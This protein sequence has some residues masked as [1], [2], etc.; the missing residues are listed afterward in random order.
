MKNLY[1]WP[2]NSATGY[3]DP[4]HYGDATYGIYKRLTELRGNTW[5]TQQNPN[6][7]TGVSDA[8]WVILQGMNKYYQ[9]DNSEGV[10]ITR[11]DIWN[12]PLIMSYVTGH[13]SLY[14]QTGWVLENPDDNFDF[15]GSDPVDTEVVLRMADDEPHGYRDGA[16][17]Y[18]T[19]GGYLSAPIYIDSGRARHAILEVLDST[20]VRLW[21]HAEYNDDGTVDNFYD[22]YRMRDLYGHRDF[23]N[24]TVY[25]SRPIVI[26]A[27]HSLDYA[28]AANVA[29]QRLTEQTNVAFS[30]EWKT[31]ATVPLPKP[32]LPVYPFSVD[33]FEDYINLFATPVSDS[34]MLISESFDFT[35][36]GSG[37]YG[38]THTYTDDYT[39]EQN[40]TTFPQFDADFALFYKAN[41]G[42]SNNDIVNVTRLDSRELYRGD[43]TNEQ[44]LATRGLYNVYWVNRLDDDHFFLTIVPYDVRTPETTARVRAADNRISWK[45]SVTD[46][47]TPGA[48][49]IRVAPLMSNS[50]GFS[51]WR[52]PDWNAVRFQTDFSAPDNYVR[53]FRDFSSAWGDELVDYNLRFGYSGR[54]S[55]PY[56]TLNFY[57][58]HFGNRVYSYTDSDGNTVKTN[59]AR[60]KPGYCY[61]EGNQLRALKT[62]ATPQYEVEYFADESGTPSTPAMAEVMPEFTVTTDSDGYLSGV[63]VVS[64]GSFNT[65]THYTW[66]VENKPNETLNT[67]PVSAAT[68]TEDNWD[69]ADQWTTTDDDASRVWPDHMR[70]RSVRVTMVQPNS[71]NR[72][73]SGIKY[74]RNTGIVRYQVEVEYPAMTEEQFT[75]FIGAVQAARGQYRPFYLRLRYPDPQAPGREVGILFNNAPESNIQT[76]L[77]VVDVDATGKVLTLDGFPANLSRAVSSGQHIGSDGNRNGG[78]NTIIQDQHSNVYG[79]S[80]FRI[81]YPSF[82]YGVGDLVDLNPSVAVVTLAEDNFEYA[83]DY[84][85][86]YKLKV[87][88]D[89]DEFK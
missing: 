10:N 88:F 82:S 49:D 75:P 20:R 6:T 35:M 80:K 69:T 47:V 61:P 29:D 33:L 59:A 12:N 16:N 76:Q 45:G 79:E 1:T 57:T 77:R 70:P 65:A 54:D 50:D 23:P 73:Q 56:T 9:M 24:Q 83:T 78:L 28:E 42:L 86:F 81:A 84:Q 68:Y 27:P 74:A 25:D 40:G 4:E 53:E 71:I 32:M 13:E 48:A 5:L 85:G 89:L 41:H 34:Y 15:T 58:A 37:T 19:Q 63:S 3:F 66:I 38:V 51:T 26:Q 43:G 18:F 67:V 8:F 11:Y 87:I 62:G 7:A 60:I 17:I 44:D 72:S 14:P 30:T 36:K 21:R 52:F 39:V 64:P 46:S 55:L 31:D 2:E 22:P